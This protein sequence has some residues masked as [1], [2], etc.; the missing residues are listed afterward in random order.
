MANAFQPNA[1]Q[2]DAFQEQISI[3]VILTGVVAVGN[4]G[5]VTIY[6]PDWGLVD[7]AQNPNWQIIIT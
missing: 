6:I 7:T 4:I 5:N 3:T 1:F 2:F